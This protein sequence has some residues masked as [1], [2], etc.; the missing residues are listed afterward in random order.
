[1]GKN[2]IFVAILCLSFVM[3][4]SQK[5]TKILKKANTK[6]EEMSF[7]EARKLYTQL[8]AKGCDSTVVYARLGDTFFF[9]ADYANALLWYDKLVEK[10]SEIA[11]EYDFRYA[12]SL[13]AGGREKESRAVFKQYYAKTG[14]RAEVHQSGSSATAVEIEIEMQSG[15]YA[16]VGSAGI[17]APFLGYGV[18]LVPNEEAYKKMTNGKN[19]K[20]AEK[21]KILKENADQRRS[22]DGYKM[23]TKQDLT[24]KTKKRSLSSVVKAE[25]LRPYTQVI[26]AKSDNDGSKKHRNKWHMKSF[27]KLY[28]ANIRE[29][30]MLENEEELSGEVNTRYSES[31]PAITKDGMTMYFTRLVPS[32]DQAEQTLWERADISKRIDNKKEISQLKLFRARKKNNKWVD[33]TELPFP[34][35]MKG[36]SSAHPALSPDDDFLYFV[37]NRNKPINDTDI[38]VVKRKERGG[39]DFKADALG[40]NINTSGRE[41]FP[42]MDSNGILYFASDGHPGFGGLDIFAAAKDPK[43]NYVVVNAGEP[44]NS[45]SDDFG[46]VIDGV[47]K[48]GYF[49]SDRDN[50]ASEDAIYKFEETTPIVFPFKVNAQYFGTIKDTTTDQPIEGV[51]VKVYNQ[52]EQIVASLI[53]DQ[54]GNFFTELPPYQQY[55]FVTAKENYQIK[56]STIQAAGSLERKE[57]EVKMFREM[58]VV[59]DGEVFD[60]QEGD[61]LAKI[62]KISALYFDYGGHSVRKST[63]AELD[64]V[65]NVLKKNPG[66][67]VEIQCH[68][69]SRGRDEFNFKL[70]KN[71]AQTIIDYILQVGEI[72]NHRISGEGYGETRLLNA[73]SNGVRCSETE[74]GANRRTDFI[75]HVNRSK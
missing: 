51:Q 10:D 23:A 54:S 3:A 36:S 30:G 50:E 47:S 49:S 71:R 40:E 62:L 8:I 11:P 59:V 73:C 19:D 72:S 31:T 32:F 45:K 74:H 15:R 33:V 56:K 53:T 42:F 28:A 9:N 46:Y 64:K 63:I 34:L 52:A 44:I 58:S 21:I 2:K 7:V 35:N 57:L 27:A 38:Y 60:L 22:S 61:N 16:A 14:M 69:D 29:N 1:M 66:L 18:R 41:T 4:F 67:S 24:Q 39:F 68:T 37:S 25:Q 55:S 75:V 20:K 12:V 43:G 26:Y 5:S 65:I 17:N 6:Y 48:K 13:R 70:S